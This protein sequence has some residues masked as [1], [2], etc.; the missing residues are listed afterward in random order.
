MDDI[1]QIEG[2][3]GRLGLQYLMDCAVPLKQQR[4]R[5]LPDFVSPDSKRTTILHQNGQMGKRED[6]P[7]PERN[8]V[9]RHLFLLH[10]TRDEQPFNLRSILLCPGKALTKSSDGAEHEFIPVTVDK[11][12]QRRDSELIKPR[13]MDR[14]ILG[15][16]R[17][18]G[19]KEKMQDL[20][21]CK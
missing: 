11:I 2:G 20:Q 13:V 15:L 10:T 5:Y 1:S 7:Q 9:V 8:V 12:V 4:R 14:R 3:E 18:S 19:R 16:G 17:K 21:L 6:R